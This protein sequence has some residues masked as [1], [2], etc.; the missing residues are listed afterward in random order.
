MILIWTL[1][2]MWQY[3]KGYLTTFTVFCSLVLNLVLAYCRIHINDPNNDDA[4][5]GSC[6][7]VLTSADMR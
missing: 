7:I 6:D 1:K 3:L 2:G 4:D 5:A